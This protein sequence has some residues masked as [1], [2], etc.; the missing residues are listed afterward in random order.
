MR[1][2]QQVVNWHIQTRTYKIMKEHFVQLHIVIDIIICGYIDRENLSSIFCCQCGAHALV[3][4]SSRLGRDGGSVILV[5]CV[6]HFI[7]V[8][9]DLMQHPCNNISILFV[10]AITGICHLYNYLKY[11]H[12]VFGKIC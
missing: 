10:L 7:R 5:S 11:Y 8:D 9:D 2:F 12:C 4:S 3:C 6:N 1:S